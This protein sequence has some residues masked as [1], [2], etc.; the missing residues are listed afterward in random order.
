MKKTI[1]CGLLAATSSISASFA[2]TNESATSIN[3]DQNFITVAGGV[4]NMASDIFDD[5]ERNYLSFKLGAEVGE[6]G[7][8]YFQVQGT[9]S[10]ESSTFTL[11]NQD[12]EQ[13]FDEH[14][15]S[16][17]VGY[18]HYFPISDNGAFFINGSLGLAYN[19]LDIE[20]NGTRLE[21]LE[22][23]S[24]YA[25]AGI[26]FEHFLTERLILSVAAKVMHV[27]DY[28]DGS[29]FVDIDGNQYAGYNVQYDSAFWGA[30]LGL[31][32]VF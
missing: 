9:A 16:F 1:L 11:F 8:L 27:G 14:I 21:S 7:N 10:D 13:K 31:T 22:G 28:K 25:D 17:S 26:G 15:I 3:W 30:E 18:T 6:A 19:S 5:S 2:G 24:F 4:T 12:F 29:S 23:N 32:Y 20:V